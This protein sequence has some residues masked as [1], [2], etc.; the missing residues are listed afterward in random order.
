VQVR[1]RRRSIGAQHALGRRSREPEAVDATLVALVDR[2]TGRL[3]KA[4]RVAR[5][6]TLRLRFAD[7][8]RATR[9]HTLLEAT[10]HTRAVL[11]VARSLLAAAQPTIEHR[12]ITLVGVAL[13][14]LEDAGGAQLPLPGDA[15]SAL[16]STLDELRERFGTEVITRAVLL[17][18]SEHPRLPQLPD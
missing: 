18:H 9:S 5:T 7:F 2:V 11:A 6:V 17:D 8:S 3:R 15:G 12:G 13:S 16:D 14:N 4:R 1:K 10:D